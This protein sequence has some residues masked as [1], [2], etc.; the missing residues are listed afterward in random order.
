MRA[1]AESNAVESRLM[2]QSLTALKWNYVGVGV[3]VLAQFLIGIVLARVLGPQPFGVY[4]VVL[5]LIG[6]GSIVVERGLGSALI[7]ADDATEELIG[8]AF[9]R[10]LLM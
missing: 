4:S 1:S 5:L 10:L 6:V 3:K 8:L 2:D 9:T 7:Q